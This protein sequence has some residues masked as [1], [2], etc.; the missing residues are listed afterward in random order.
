MPQLPTELIEEIVHQIPVFRREDALRQASL[1]CRA[2]RGPCQRALFTRLLF[3]YNND[4]TTGKP[5]SKLL[6]IFRETP[7]LSTYVQQ[8]TIIDARYDW[9][10]LADDA[11]LAGVLLLLADLGNVTVFQCA[12]AKEARGGMPPKILQAIS[13]LSG[14][15]GLAEGEFSFV[16]M[17]MIQLR[18]RRLS[19]LTLRCLEDEEWT[20][21]DIQNTEPV[22]PR[23][24]VKALE[25]HLNEALLDFAMDPT[26]GVDLT[27]LE[28]LHLRGGHIP[29]NIM[30]PLASCEGNLRLLR[31]GDYRSELSLF[32]PFL[33]CIANLHRSPLSSWI[34]LDPSRNAV[35][36]R[37]QTRQ[38]C[39][40]RNSRISRQN[41]WLKR[42][43]HSCDRN[44]HSFEIAYSVEA[45]GPDWELE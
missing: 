6:Q 15:P 27:A 16:P 17:P 45:V 23:P 32:F 39:I 11:D 8:V 10:K 34:V 14:T 44:F 7:I 4:L 41:I 28:E 19:K 26:H 35:G 12:L 18:T 36:G 31:I 24:Q 33:R 22:L 37:T 13:A 21:Q 40:D 20:P 38:K 43:T 9:S 5:G 30:R 2:F 29:R 3:T 1:V 42:S 25:L